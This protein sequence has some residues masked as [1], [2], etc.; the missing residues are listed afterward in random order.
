MCFEDSA[1]K[2]PFKVLIDMLSKEENQRVYWAS[3]RGMLELDLMIMPFTRE[4]LPYLPAEDQRRFIDLLNNEDSDLF[5]WLMGHQ[6]PA[7]PALVAIIAQ[8]KE[9]RVV[10]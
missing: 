6:T 5:A 2:K 10:S 3:R 8:I 4:R 1:L 7:D 9:Y